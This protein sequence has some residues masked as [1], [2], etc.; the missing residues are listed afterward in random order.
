M[1]GG[2][3][4]VFRLGLGYVEV[5]LGEGRCRRGVRLVGLDDFM[6]GRRI[7]FGIL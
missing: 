7:V 3:T 1:C 6:S 2:R 4:E 5:T